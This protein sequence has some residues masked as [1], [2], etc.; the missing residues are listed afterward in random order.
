MTLKPKYVFTMTQEEYNI[1]DEFLDLLCDEANNIDEKDFVLD[2]S[3]IYAIRMFVKE[4]TN[5]VKEK[6][7]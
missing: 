2:N 6:E 7:W 5:I 1:V 4:N 3:E